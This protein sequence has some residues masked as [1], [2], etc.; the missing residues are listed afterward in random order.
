[1]QTLS[2]GIWDLT[3]WP[4]IEPGPLHW[5]FGVLATGLPG[6]SLC[7]LFNIL[8]PSL[9]TMLLCYW[10]SLS[11][12]GFP[13]SSA[14][15][16]CRRPQFNSWVRKIPWRR[17]R[18]PTPVFWGFLCGSA[19]KESICNAGDLG[20]I[21]GSGRSSGEGKGYSSILAWRITWTV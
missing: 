9:T 13:D 4:G 10:H 18:L 11:Q 16:Q 5:E 7:F 12:G 19:G 2:C 21:P 6:H 3:L 20:L 14:G 1:M 17:D 15:M 8:L